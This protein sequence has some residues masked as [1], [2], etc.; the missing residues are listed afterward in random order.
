MKN[1]NINNCCGKCFDIT[2]PNAF[3]SPHNG[4]ISCHNSGKCT[5]AMRDK[6]WNAWKNKYDKEK[7]E[8]EKRKILDDRKEHEKI[9]EPLVK[10]INILKKE[11][12]L[13]KMGGK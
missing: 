2:C 8:T 11:V 6:K 10:E 12:K 9:L 1:E 5:D 4:D 13:L 3:E 7:A